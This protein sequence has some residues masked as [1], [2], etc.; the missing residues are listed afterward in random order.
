MPFNAEVPS[1]MF[2]AGAGVGNCSVAVLPTQ[3]M[4]IAHMG[5]LDSGGLGGHWEV[6]APLFKP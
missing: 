4:V 5:S 6:F 1:D 3:R 2:H